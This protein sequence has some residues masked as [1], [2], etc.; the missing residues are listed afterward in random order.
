MVLTI[1]G[2]LSC[3]SRDLAYILWNSNVLGESIWSRTFATEPGRPCLQ[4]VL[5]SYWAGAAPNSS[6]TARFDF[7]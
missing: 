2:M 4:V 3:A 1:Y 5:S 7:R 6:G